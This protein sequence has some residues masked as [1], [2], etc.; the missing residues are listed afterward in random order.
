MKR[1]GLKEASAHTG[2]TIHELRA[3]ALSGKYPYMR[4]GGQKGKFWFD[5]DLLDSAIERHMLNNA[6]HVEPEARLGTVRPIEMKKI[7]GR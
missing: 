7:V 2:L 1:G 3:G 5:F 6:A 4:I